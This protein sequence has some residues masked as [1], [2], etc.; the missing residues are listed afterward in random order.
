MKKSRKAEKMKRPESLEEI[1]AK[2]TRFEHQVLERK[3]G[4]KEIVEAV[5]QDV[6]RKMKCDSETAFRIIYNAYISEL[7]FVSFSLKDV[8]ETEDI[9][10]YTA[11]ENRTGG[12]L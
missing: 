6:K 3:Y 11:Y 12:V 9:E 10:Q 4:R 8:T 7:I 5:L 2:C 1:S